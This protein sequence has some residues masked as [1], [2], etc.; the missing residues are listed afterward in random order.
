MLVCAKCHKDAARQVHYC[1]RC[2]RFPPLSA[3][4]RPSPERIPRSPHLT[5][6]SRPGDSTCQ[7]SDFPKHK[8]TCGVRLRT[9]PETLPPVVDP[10]APFQPPPALLFHLAALTTLPP[11]AAPNTPP[12]SF[13]YFPTSPTASL[14]SSSSSSASTPQPVPISLAPATRNLFNALS[15]VAFR[16]ANP[17]SVNLMFSLLLTEVE[18]LGGAEDRL[19]EQLAE[20]YRLDGEQELVPGEGKRKSLRETLKDEDEPRPEQ[21]VEAIGGEQNMGLLRASLSLSLC[22][23]IRRPLL[24]VHTSADTHLVS[25][26]CSGSSRWP[27]RASRPTPSNADEPFPPPSPSESCGPPSCPLAS[28]CCRVRA[29]RSSYL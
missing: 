12:P 3:A 1:S 5:S 9:L 6:L 4:A 26:Q 20:E 22:V 29:P 19:V 27:S 15:L 14:S 17:L 21:L 18:A 2:A 24:F 8:P 13:L 11:P 7:V 10:S 28:L 23:W 25:L 16:T